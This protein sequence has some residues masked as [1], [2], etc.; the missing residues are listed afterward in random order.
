MN[1]S[2]CYMK[3]ILY[4]VLEIPEVDKRCTLS[5]LLGAQSVELVHFEQIADLKKSHLVSAALVSPSVQLDL[6]LSV[7]EH[8][9]Y[10][11]MDT[12]MQAFG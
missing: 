2:T 11:K 4:S 8:V 10:I 12:H 9:A 6:L 5:L 1:F 7:H 3:H